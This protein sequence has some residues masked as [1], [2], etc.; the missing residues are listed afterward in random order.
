MAKAKYFAIPVSK[1][2]TQ[3]AKI[4]Y[5]KADKN[6]F[7]DNKH[8]YIPIVNITSDAKTNKV[9]KQL[10]G[11]NRYKSYRKNA[12]TEAMTKLEERQREFDIFITNLKPDI[13][14]MEKRL[15]IG[16]RFTALIN[17]NGSD[18]ENHLSKDEALSELMKQKYFLTPLDA[19]LFYE[20]VRK[21]T[22]KN[23]KDAKKKEKENELDNLAKSISNGETSL[24]MDLDNKQKIEFV[25]WI[26]QQ[27]NSLQQSFNKTKTL[28]DSKKDRI[29]L[30][31]SLVENLKLE[32]M[33]NFLGKSI[34]KSYYG[35]NDTITINQSSSVKAN[36]LKR[37]EEKA[38]RQI[39]IFR[40][41]KEKNKDG[42][43]RISMLSKEQRLSLYQK[44]EKVFKPLLAKIK[45]NHTLSPDE[46]DDL[47]Y[48]FKAM[49][50][51]KPVSRTIFSIVHDKFPEI[52]DVLSD[53]LLL[54][55]SE[56]RKKQMQVMRSK[57]QNIQ[58]TYKDEWITSID[59]EFKHN[60]NKDA[61]I[62]EIGYTLKNIAKKK[63]IVKN[64]IV[65]ENAKRSYK[66][67]NDGITKH[68]SMED[69]IKELNRDFLRVKRDGGIIVG[70]GVQF[71]IDE[72][73][74][75]GAELHTNKVIDLAQMLTFIDKNESLISLQS[76][77]EILNI[78]Y[79]NLHNAA[80]DSYYSV[81]GFVKLLMKYQNQNHDNFI[82]K[83]VTIKMTNQEVTPKKD[84]T[85]SDKKIKAIHKLM[86]KPI[87]PRIRHHDDVYKDE[88]FL[89]KDF[90]KILVEDIKSTYPTFT[91]KDLF[92][93][94]K[95]ELLEI[96]LIAFKQN[97]FVSLDNTVYI[98]QSVQ[99]KFPNINFNTQ[100]IFKENTIVNGT[101]FSIISS[102]IFDDS[103]MEIILTKEMSEIKE[104]IE[105]KQTAR[106]LNP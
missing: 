20:F 18:S 69:A 41:F 60:K 65:E 13:I 84:R 15:E 66:P 59:L 68:T 67:F 38:K 57:L 95:E 88:I 6:S 35:E 11:E 24:F 34:L 5:D 72:I 44:S 97:V 82:K 31:L 93:S 1:I 10:L 85:N 47:L 40:Y 4:I 23:V 8:V 89:F 86:E 7:L 19:E 14:K 55:D 54:K 42:S 2:N 52:K 16:Q 75:N 62:F 77:L 51:H 64:F 29:A 12:D 9:F 105:K 102:D 103:M 76:L 100:Q 49:G 98:V 36:K 28:N 101:D 99:K 45:H 46:K 32:N 58:E 3:I 63:L 104:N 43:F 50:L 17:N 53:S 21:Q 30:L 96:Q 74:K 87:E 81:R 25:S 90:Y 26:R 22:A 94:I 61:T 33:N 80:N 56:V 27:A 92:N 106:T 37:K 78:E 71:D 83:S 70:N 48:S 39:E 79:K 91:F 73:I